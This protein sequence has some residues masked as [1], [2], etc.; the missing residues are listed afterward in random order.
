MSTVSNAAAAGTPASAYTYAPTAAANAAATGPAANAANDPA[1]AQDR[2]LKLL[3]AQLSNQ[4]PMNPMDNAQMTSQ[5]AQINTVT[6]ITQ[7]NSTVKDMASQISGMQVLQGGA[8]V[9]REVVTEGNALTK[10]A[11]A[12]TAGGMFDLSGPAADVQV[13]VTT[14]G[15]VLLGTMK[16][17]PLDAGRHDFA[18]DGAGAAGKDALSFA[19]R[20][21]NAGTA[22]A[23]TALRKDTVKSVGAEGGSLNLMLQSGGTVAYGKVKSIL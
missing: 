14:A 20:A 19:V 10:D 12:G 21:A 16:L 9:G 17:G 22:V 5:I 13:D 4:D 18:W 1:T 7:L 3:V 15:G 6:G 2:F 11:K 23:S 8:L